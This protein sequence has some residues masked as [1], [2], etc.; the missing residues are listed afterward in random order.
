MPKP[1]NATPG[2]RRW[3]LRKHGLK[4]GVWHPELT[5]YKGYPK[6]QEAYDKLAAAGRKRMAN[7]RARGV[8]LNPTGIPNG[9]GRRRVELQRIRIA[10]NKR[11]K[12]LV[13]EM[14]EKDML[15][16]DDERA[17]AALRGAVE[18]V[19]E[20]MSDD[21]RY[22][23]SAD[24]RLKAMKLVLDFCKSKPVQKTETTVNGAE[25]W[26]AALAE[27]VSTTPKK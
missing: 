5:I 22:T 4:P 8:K 17:E 9:W 24:H 18:I 23:Y 19:T 16:S 12:E 11:A 6:T 20:T 27:T 10:A 1:Q 7:L 14:K 26:L 3:T 21:G 25:G 2:T 15:V 13:A